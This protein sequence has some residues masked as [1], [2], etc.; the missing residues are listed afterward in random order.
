[1]FSS[2]ERC[3][4]RD[5]VCPEI[6]SKWSSAFLGAEKRD[7]YNEPLTANAAWWEGLKAEEI[8]IVASADECMTD[9]VA[10]MGEILKVSHFYFFSLVFLYLLGS[11]GF[12]FWTLTK[13]KRPNLSTV[14]TPQ[15]YYHPS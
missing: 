11:D 12:Y 9:D 10:S 15:H 5:I 3:K 8:L 6:G 14:G 13:Q 7:E 1:M 4:N 2:I